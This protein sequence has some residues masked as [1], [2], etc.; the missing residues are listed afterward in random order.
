MIRSEEAVPFGKRTD[1]TSRLIVHPAGDEPLDPPIGVDD[2][3]RGVLR[4]DERTDAIDDHLQGVIDRCQSGDPSDRGI[5]GSLNLV[6]ASRHGRFR[7]D[8]P[9][10]DRAT[11]P[12]RRG[13]RGPTPFSS[14]S[15]SE[16]QSTVMRAWWPAAE[17]EP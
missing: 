16:T 7:L 6:Q 2:P 9:N 17:P 8:H 14:G 10:E 5:E 11:T 12:K 13:P 3:Q 1:L 15:G 4:A